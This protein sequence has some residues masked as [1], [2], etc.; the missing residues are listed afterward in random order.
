M[1]ITSFL[2]L[3]SKS[4]QFGH[5]S[6]VA[7]YLRSWLG[8]KVLTHDVYVGLYRYLHGDILRVR[9]FIRNYPTFEFVWRKVVLLSVHMDKTDEVELQVR[10]WESIET[11][12]GDI[13]EPC[14][15]FKH[16]RLFLHT[17]SLRCVLGNRKQRVSMIYCNYS[18]V[19]MWLYNTKHLPTNHKSCKHL[20]LLL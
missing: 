13:N 20:L 11:F 10:Y 14:W 15:L 4:I 6:S 5:T 12:G 2:A 9:S 19:F 8:W 17:R 16:S 3:F 1:V 18:Y 7:Y